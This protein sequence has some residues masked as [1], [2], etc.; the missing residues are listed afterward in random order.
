ME[1]KKFIAKKA[2]I[3]YVLNIIKMYSSTTTP[4]SQTAICR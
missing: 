4:V 1:D 3:V 2:I